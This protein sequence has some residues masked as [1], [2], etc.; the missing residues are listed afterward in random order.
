[1][2]GKALIATLGFDERHVVKSLI[3]I[4]MSGVVRIVLLVP[5]WGLDERTMKA[6]DTITHITSLAGID[7]DAIIVREVSVL[8]PWKGIRDIMNILYD[9]YTY[10]V[11]EIIISLGGGLRALVIETYTAALLVDPEITSKI[12]IRIGIEGRSEYISYKIEE[13]PICLRIDEQEILVLKTIEKGIDKLSDIARETKIP[14]STTWKILQKLCMKKIL[15]K[16]NR[17]YQLT[18]L[19]KT[20]LKLY[21]TQTSLD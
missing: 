1:M 16:K 3:D 17:R 2:V 11:D 20:L 21:L 12:T 6:I 18:N 15:E 19:G 10:G 5:D 13:I 14:R 4:G 8:D 9:T 7:R